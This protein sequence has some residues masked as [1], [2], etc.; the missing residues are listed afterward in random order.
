MTWKR[1]ATLTGHRGAVYALESTAHPEQWLSGSGDGRVV[2]WDLRE[3]ERGE[4]IADAAV[5]VYSLYKDRGRKLLFIGNG[6]G[7]LHVID[8]TEREELRLLQAHRKGIFSIT[9]LGTDRLLCTGGDGCISVWSLPSMDLQRN[10]P[11]SDE[12]VRSAAVSGDGASVAFACGDGTIRVL[13]TND[14]NEHASIEA[15]AKGTGSISWHPTKPML[16]SGGRDGYL[17]AWRVDNGFAQALAIP[18]HRA[19]IYGIAFSP[20]GRMIATASRDKTVKLWDAQDLSPI[21]KFDLAIGGHTHSVNTARWCA[22][23]SL[24]SASDD[25][26]IMLWQDR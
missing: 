2:R 23:G 14:L 25:K 6:N 5:P 1:Q 10:I 22:N 8:L 9:P 26:R 17:R 15:H 13:D 16:M 19:N 11:L 7:G 12:K 18:A 3:P 4:L 21:A 24:I 20:D